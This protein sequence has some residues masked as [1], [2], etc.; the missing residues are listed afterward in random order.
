MK[1][2][3][4]ITSERAN[5]GQGGNNKLEIEIKAFDRDNP[6]AIL[7]LFPWKD[8]LEDKTPHL[9]IEMIEG[10]SHS[11]EV[12][13]TLGAN[14]HDIDCTCGDCPHSNEYQKAK[15]QT[16]EDLN[17]AIDNMFTTEGRQ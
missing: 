3:A 6:I 14:K 10:L 12:F 13:K 16:G 5:K 17:K 1:L 9:C 15:K 7:T 2:Y 8:R 11:I 4:T